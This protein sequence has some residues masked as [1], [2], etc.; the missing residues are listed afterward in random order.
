M[1]IAMLHW[2]FPPTIGGVETHLVLLGRGL[3]RLGHSVHLLTGLAEGQPPEATEYVWSGMRIRRTPLLSLNGRGLEDFARQRSEIEREISTFIER[4]QPDLVHAHNMHYFSPVHAEAVMQACRRLNLPLALTAHNTWEDGLWWR[5]CALADGWDGVIA[6]SRY[7]RNELERSGY[8]PYRIR[9]IHHG[10]DTRQFTPPDPAEKAR[11]QEEFPFLQGRR[12]IFH[13]A[14]MGRAKGC[15]VSIRALDLVRRRIPE[16]LLVLAGNG[17]IVDWGA[18]QSGE[19]QYM[20]Q[21]IDELGLREHVYIQCF[22]WEQMPKIYRLS[23]I[24]IYPSAVHEPFGLAMLEAMATGKPLVVTES[25]GMPEVVKDGVNGLVVP[26]ADSRAL[27]EACLRL[28]EDRELADRLAQTGLEMVQRYWSL[29][30]MTR[31][32]VNFYRWLIQTKGREKARPQAI[33][34]PARQ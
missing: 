23:E 27:A 10:I 18:V 24:V 2:A 8:S 17:N 15:H 25:G 6:V 16:V 7:I 13:P 19:V 22:P 30:V 9:V 4:V 20:Q 29:E 14:R 21:L 26:R 1:R 11:L 5:M 31:N 28:L 33:F 34:T 12:V 3:V 32:T